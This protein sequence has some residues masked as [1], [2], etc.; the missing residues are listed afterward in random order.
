MLGDLSQRTIPKKQVALVFRNFGYQ[1]KSYNGTK[2]NCLSGRYR[3]YTRILP[4]FSFGLHITYHDLQQF[5]ISQSYDINGKSRF[6]RKLMDHLSGGI[7]L[8]PEQ[9]FNIRMGYNLKRN[10]LRCF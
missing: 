5:N 2:N 8:F 7:E 1:I 6:V 3:I 10:E 9:A 4:D